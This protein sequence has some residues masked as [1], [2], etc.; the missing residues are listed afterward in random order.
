MSLDSKFPVPG[1]ISVISGV[2]VPCFPLHLRS[3]KEKRHRRSRSASLTAKQ[4]HFIFFESG[5]RS[6]THFAGTPWNTWQILGS[7][8]FGKKN[9]PPL[10]PWLPRWGSGASG[11]S[12]VRSLSS[13]RCT[14]S[15]DLRSKKP[16]VAQGPR[17]EAA[18]RGDVGAET[19]EMG[20]DEVSCVKF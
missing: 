14:R 1:L 7:P 4:I 3:P 17:A 11:S 20:S 5:I 9:H 15:V 19:R 18:K 10:R 6:R 16:W 8:R 13:T 12:T 2:P